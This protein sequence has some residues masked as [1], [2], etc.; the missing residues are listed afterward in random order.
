MIQVPIGGAI[1]YEDPLVISDEDRLY[2]FLQEDHVRLYGVDIK[3]RLEECGF[4][5]ELLSS[6]DVA[7]EDRVLFG[8]DAQH[9]REIFFC[10]R[11]AAA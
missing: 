2:K 9:F 6:D 8:V 10:R 4:H 5:C 7:P 1:T 3:G 11:P